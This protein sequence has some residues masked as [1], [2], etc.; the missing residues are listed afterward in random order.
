MVPNPAERKD[1]QGQG[2]AHES[3]DAQDRHTRRRIIANGGFGSQYH[4][5]NRR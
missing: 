5:R 4:P 1:N 2:N 3:T